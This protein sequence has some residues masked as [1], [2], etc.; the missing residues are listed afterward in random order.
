MPRR[1]IL[2]ALT[3]IL[4]ATP[5][6]TPKAADNQQDT[7]MA[8]IGPVGIVT[9]VAR[10]AGWNGRRGLYRSSPAIPS[11]TRTV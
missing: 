10:E 4:V 5:F 2:F 6:T 9:R 3:A 11:P 8:G 1:L 7:A